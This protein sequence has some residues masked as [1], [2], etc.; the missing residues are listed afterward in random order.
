MKNFA[1]IR[2]QELQFRAEAF[3]VFNHPLFTGAS[4]SVTS[5]TLGQATYQMNAPRSMQFSLRFSF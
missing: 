2:N 1:I 3:N 5:P 4:N